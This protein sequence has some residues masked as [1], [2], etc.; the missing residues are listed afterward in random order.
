MFPRKPVGFPHL[1]LQT[2]GYRAPLQKGLTVVGL[3][4]KLSLRLF[5]AGHVTSHGVQLVKVSIVTQ[6]AG[7]SSSLR[8]P[9]FLHQAD[10]AMNTPAKFPPP[11]LNPSPS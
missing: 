8:S 11:I 5:W 6:P 1:F 10:Q 4:F 2:P 9:G 3:P 7:D